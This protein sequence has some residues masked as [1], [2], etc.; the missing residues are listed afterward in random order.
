MTEDQYLLESRPGSQRPI[1]V[2]CIC[3]GYGFPYGIAST[4]RVRML[5][6]AFLS[7]GIDFRLLHCGTSPLNGNTER[8]GTHAGIRF[9]YTSPV[10]RRPSSK[11]VRAIVY[12]YAYV[13]LT[14]RLFQLRP[15]K[16]AKRVVYL[17][18]LGGPAQV[19]VTTI[20]R[21]LR[22]P[23][24]QDVC[25]WWPG[26]EKHSWFT[27]WVYHRFM[28]RSASGAVAISRVIE[29]RLEEISAHVS[30][31]MHVLRV[32][33][34]LDSNQIAA[35]PTNTRNGL[36][37]VLWL[38]SVDGY[39]QDVRFIIEAVARANRDGVASRLV[40][41]GFASETAK[42]GAAEMA[43]ASGLAPD[44]VEVTGF[45]P[46]E[47]MRELCMT[48]S[49]LMLPMWKDDRSLTRYPHKIG[50]YLMAGRP[51]ITC[52]VGEIAALLE[53]NVSAVFYE[54]GDIQSCADK[55][56]QLHENPQQA[57]EIGRRGRE[58]AR[59]SLDYRV[60]ARPLEMLATDVLSLA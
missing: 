33:V 39:P 46:D 43:K 25:E 2:V 32:P 9:E 30:S 48:A 13:V 54:P 10:V 55:I 16:G 49:A 60:Y 52:A 42:V 45:V 51:V 7:R 40:C 57:D 8:K 38:G 21:M 4:D 29:D 47:T 11:V 26:T 17:F 3:G 19:Y 53:D 58:C 23:V 15:R 50:D 20:C 12:L 41:V 14:L 27:E 1:E 34:L 59:G 35:V 24:I 18:L 22:L 56:R 28:L 36:P 44:V 37:Y 5:G 6:K 31:P